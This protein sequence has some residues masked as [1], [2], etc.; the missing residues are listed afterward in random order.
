MTKQKKF[1][2]AIALQLVIIF[3]II[4]FKV[5][6]LTGGVDV[7]LKI[8]PVDPRDPLRG[9]YVT[10]GYN[11][12]SI[13]PH[14]AENPSEIKNGDTVY[15]TLREGNQYWNSTVVSIKKPVAGIFIKGKVIGGGIESKS[16]II[17]DIGFRQDSDIRIIYGI[18][19]YFIPEGK[20]QGFIFGDKEAVAR[21]AVDKDGNSVLKQI[22]INNELWP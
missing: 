19:E 8:E 12:S 21:V 20:G 11:I 14:S 5:A 7:V 22:Y 13:N 18:E 16:D 3:I 2:I 6:V 15:V 10:F 9:D 4:I 17:G 1:I